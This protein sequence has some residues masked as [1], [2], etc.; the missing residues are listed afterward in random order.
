MWMTLYYIAYNERDVTIS[1]PG[2]MSILSKTK[3]K[4]KS[5]QSRTIKV[6]SQDIFLVKT[7][8]TVTDQPTIYGVCDT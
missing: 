1:N 5:Q 4:I 3:Q 2:H 7:L 8:I 6:V